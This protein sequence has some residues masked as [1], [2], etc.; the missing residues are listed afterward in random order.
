M[1]NRIRR[2]KRLLHVQSRLL[3]T[4]RLELQTLRDALAV[5]QQ[6]EQKAISLLNQES[7]LSSQLTDS[8]GCFVRGTN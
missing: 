8:K 5:A 7:S 3:L 6:E 2:A 1:R 4:E